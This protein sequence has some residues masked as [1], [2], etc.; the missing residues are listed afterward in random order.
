MLKINVA[1]TTA[2]LGWALLACPAVAADAIV[3]DASAPTD[4]SDIIVTGRL[5]PTEGLAA[6]KTATPLS[7]TPQSISVISN[8]E[9]TTLGLRNLAQSLRFVAGVTPEQRGSSA[10]V[11]DLFTLRGFAAPVFLDGLYYVYQTDGT[12][13]AAAQADISRIERVEVIKG[14]SSALYGR[15]GPGGLVVEESKRPLD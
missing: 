9:I 13:Y 14:P 4:M 6:T 5:P 12:G 3:A 2:A 8:E 10:E 7:E 15:S 1:G 11:Y